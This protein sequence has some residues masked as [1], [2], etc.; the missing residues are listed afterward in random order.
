MFLN[1]LPLLLNKT[2][3]VQIITRRAVY[4]EFAPNWNIVNQQAT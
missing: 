1:L 4:T 3:C 2:L